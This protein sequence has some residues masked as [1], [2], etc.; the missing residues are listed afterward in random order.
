MFCSFECGICLPE[1]RLKCDYCFCSVRAIDDDDDDDDDRI[2][3]TFWNGILLQ[4]T[5]NGMLKDPQQQHQTGGS[6]R[7]G[8]FYQPNHSTIS[9]FDHC[10]TVFFCWFHD[11]SSSLFRF[12]SLFV[13][14]FFLLNI[15]DNSTENHSIQFNPRPEWI[16]LCGTFWAKMQLRFILFKNDTRAREKTLYESGNSRTEDEFSFFSQDKTWQAYL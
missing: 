6:A 9:M 1:M 8:W 16:D 11:S 7:S 14:W 15:V 3:L 10:S 5:W 2:A 4:F 13:F 12:S